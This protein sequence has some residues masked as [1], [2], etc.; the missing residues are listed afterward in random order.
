MYGIFIIRALLATV[1]SRSRGNIYNYIAVILFFLAN[2]LKLYE[3]SYNYSVTGCML[4]LMNTVSI[5]LHGRIIELKNYKKLLHKLLEEKMLKIDLSEGNPGALVF[6]MD[7]H[8]KNPFAT[9][10]AFERMNKFGIRDSKLYILWN[11]CCKRDTEK[12]IL[13]MLNK[14]AEEIIRHINPDDICG[15]PFD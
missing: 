6:M 4:V 15:I 12:T 3:L 7:A 9:E 14:P 2:T 1:Y 13:V 8:E 10:L 11:D 5:F